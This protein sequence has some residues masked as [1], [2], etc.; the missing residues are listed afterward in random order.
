MPADFLPTIVV[1]LGLFVA[2][3][4]A[5]LAGFAFNL[6]AA[7]I[8][9]HF[10]SPQVLAPV[11]VLGNLVVQSISLPTV[12]RSVRWRPL[13]GPILAGVLGLPIGILI[14]RVAD[15]RQVGIIVGVLL[16]GYG[17]YALARMALRIK[18]R[19]VAANHWIDKIVGFLSGILGGIGGFS[20]ALPAMWVDL[21]GLT[22]EEARAR[23]QPFVTTM[24]VITAACLALGGF[25]T[26][27]TGWT[28]LTGLPAL[29]LGTWLGL[30][31]YRIIPAQGFRL[32]LV[33]LLFLS[34]ISLLL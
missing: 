34:G 6:I 29:M 30:K 28:L 19:P 13:L 33:G 12:L 21:Q 27:E 4:C 20:G 3:F 24:Q 7:G 17:G 5:G 31:A 1:P 18:P 14:L 15:P 8:L 32:V 2:A 9:L 25:V 22:K 23:L 11:L 16:A 10:V 26:R